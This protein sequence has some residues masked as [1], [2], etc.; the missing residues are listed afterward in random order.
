[1]LQHNKLYQSLKKLSAEWHAG[2]VQWSYTWNYFKFFE[3][4]TFVYGSIQGENFDLINKNF[5]KGSENL[6]KGKY[7]IIGSLITIY[8]ENAEVKGALSNDNIVLEG[9]LA[10]D[11]YIPVA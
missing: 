5:N 2:Y 1:M 3:D 6:I 9:K 7:N 10:W 11:I 8:F 4:K